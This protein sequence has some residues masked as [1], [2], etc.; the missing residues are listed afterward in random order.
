[1]Q[2]KQKKLKQKTNGF[3]DPFNDNDDDV[4]R[5]A[6]ELEKKYGSAYS[7]GRGRNKKDDLCDIGLGYD[8]SDSFIDNTEAVRI[9]SCR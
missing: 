2:K 4:A 9:P 3:T 7:S 6:R 8:E 1:M 5:I